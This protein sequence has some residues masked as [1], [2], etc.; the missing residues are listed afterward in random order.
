MHISA[1]SP[2]DVRTKIFVLGRYKL[3]KSIEPKML[4]KDIIYENCDTFQSRDFQLSIEAMIHEIH[5]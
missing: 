4:V 1:N 3:L 5:L 2:I